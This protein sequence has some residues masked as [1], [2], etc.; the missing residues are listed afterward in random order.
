MLPHKIPPV[1]KS[2]FSVYQYITNF[3]YLLCY[4]A[5]LFIC[6]INTIIAGGPGGGGGG[7]EWLGAAGV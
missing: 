6:T 5:L 4:P 3:L 1:T 2:F 7:G